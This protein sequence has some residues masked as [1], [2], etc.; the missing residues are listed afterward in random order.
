MQGVCG[1]GG[2][3]AI[4]CFAYWNKIFYYITVD[5]ISQLLSRKLSI[6]LLV[7]WPKEDPRLT[8]LPVTI[9]DFGMCYMLYVISCVRCGVCVR[10]CACARTCR[11]DLVYPL[12]DVLHLRKECIHDKN[13]DRIWEKTIIF[14][15]KRLK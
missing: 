1:G 4:T 9:S 6:V 8:M 7:L 14:G 11:R 5:V 13:T 10:A 3:G 12:Q 15:M 2:G